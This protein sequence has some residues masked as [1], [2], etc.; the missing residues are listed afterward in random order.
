MRMGRHLAVSNGVW[1]TTPVDMVL[2]QHSPAPQTAHCPGFA[3]GRI[4]LWPSHFYTRRRL[5]A[6]VP[7]LLTW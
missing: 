1:R 6:L 4:R 7:S 5:S 2:A 3:K